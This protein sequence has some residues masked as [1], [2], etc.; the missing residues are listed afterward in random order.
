MQYTFYVKQQIRLSKKFL[1]MRARG[2][3]RRFGKISVQ[4]L[5]ITGRD[6]SATPP[7]K[8]RGYLKEQKYPEEKNYHLLL[9]A[10]D[11]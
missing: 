6:S 10:Q 4:P 2:A 7:P 8:N 9:P 5:A 3:L 1:A 11:E